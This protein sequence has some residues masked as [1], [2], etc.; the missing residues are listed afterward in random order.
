MEIISVSVSMYAHI[1][2]YIVYMCIL[3]QHNC[4]AFYDIIIQLGN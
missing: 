2:Y 1:S 4:V 3:I